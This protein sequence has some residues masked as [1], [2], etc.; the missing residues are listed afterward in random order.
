MAETRSTCP[1]CGVGCGVII[2]SQGDQITG[3]RGDPDH[4]ANFGR[5]CTKGSTLALT[6]SAE[7]TRHTR[8]LQPM[9]RLKRHEAPQPVSW[10]HALGFASER[11]ASIITEHGP[12]AVGFYISG[13]LLTE[14]YYVFNKLAKGLIGTNNVDTNSRL[15]MSSAV[16]GYKQTLGADAPPNCYDDV[17]HAQCIFIVGS[18]T[19]YAHPVLFRRIEDA[20]AANPALQIIFCDPRRTDTAEIADLYLPIQPGTDVSLFNGLL[21]IMLWEGWT[22]NAWIAAHTTGFEAL[23]A[24]VRDYTPDLVAETCGIKKDD[25][26]AAAKMFATSKATLSLYCQGLNQSSSGTAKNAALINLHLATAQIGK[27]GAGP[28][29]LTGQPNAMGGREVGGLASLLSAHRDMAN[30]DHRAEIASLWGVD[31][32][33]EKPGK[34]AVEMFQAAADG[35]IKALWIA[36]TN[37]A[38]SMPD[39]T[40]VRR[41]ME[42]AELVIVQ[43]AFATTSSCDY[44]DLLLPATTWGEKTGTVTNSERRISRV[45]PAVA[46]PGATRHDWAI[47]VDFARRLEKQLPSRSTSSKTLFPYPIEDETAGVEVIWNEHRESTRGRDLDITGMS[48]TLLEQAPLQWPMRSGETAGKVRLYEDGV[49]PTADGKAR[50]ANTVYKPVAEPRESRFPF[51][52]TTGRLRDQWH[53]MS[54]TGTLGRLFGHVPEPSVQM[55]AQDMARRLLKDGDLVHVTSK[56]GSIVVPVQSSPEVAASQAFIAM[57]WGAEYLAGQSSTGL[58]LAG[59]NAITTS[60]YCPTSKQPEL[61]HA[62]VKILKAEMPWTLTAMAWLP[63]S[64]ALAAREQLKSLMTAFPFTSCVPFSSNTALNDHHRER[65]GVLFRAAAHDAPDDALLQSLEKVLGLDGADAL[66]YVDHKKGQRRTVRLV[67]NK[68]QSDQ[69]RLAG[70]VLAG[71]TS[72]QAW[73]KTLLK[74]ELPAQTYGRLL[75]LPGAK[76]PAAVT[77]SMKERGKLVC[78][79]FNVSDTAIDAHLATVSTGGGGAG[80]LDTDEERLTSLQDALKCGTNCGSCVPELKRRIRSASSA[81][82]QTAGTPERTVIPIKQLA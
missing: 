17:N 57:H 37:P 66:R 63:G 51:S 64:D 14:D 65:T 25:L 49:F 59:V 27:P 16:A 35:E 12:D 21:H 44:A 68:D 4:P 79:C 78:T 82:G 72:A 20:K 34:T 70:F 69:A 48:Y 62:A 52:L 81:S 61:K 53:G 9:Q 7:V 56:R 55:N 28:F 10:D 13:Q 76:P 2:E 18:N 75:L 36:C 38:Q 42:R 47:A 58:P 74:D 3:V 50:F 30:P 6:A 54:R 32:V 29:S 41:A 40:T 23:K 15:C 67:R 22:D 1:Y 26:F 31:S 19:A 71:D 5:L 73:I 77:D 46:A 33:P 60:A 39:Q 11:F 24:T 43:E 8:L 45:R 80:N